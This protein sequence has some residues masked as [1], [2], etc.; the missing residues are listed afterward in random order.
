MAKN[1]VIRNN[2]AD[3]RNVGSLRKTID[4]LL[5]D[6]LLEIF[7]FLQFLVVES[8]GFEAENWWR[9]LVHVC[10]KWRNVIFGSTNRLNLRLVCSDRT[11]V[12]ET[13]DLWPPTLPIVIHHF[14]R[15]QSDGDNI[16]TIVYVKSP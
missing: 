8:D 11:P 14:A 15:P 7:D 2:S 1:P 5:D 12:R 6:V 16:A 9:T 4:I 3:W 10:R 13:L